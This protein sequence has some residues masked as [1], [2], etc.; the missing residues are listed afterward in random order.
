MKYTFEEIKQAQTSN[1]W[2]I[3]NNFLYE[4][5]EQYPLHNDKAVFLSKIWLIGRSYSAA[6]E[7]RKQ[8]NAIT[9]DE[10]YEDL[11]GEGILKVGSKI[12]ESIKLL[13]PHKKISFENDTKILELHHLL[14]QTFESLTGMSKRSLASKYLHF[15]LPQL[16]YIYDSR[17]RNAI[18]E[19]F[20]SDSLLNQRL[21]SLSKTLKYDDDYA[22]FSNK[23]FLLNQEIENKYDIWL[24][25]RELDNL[26]LNFNNKLF[27]FFKP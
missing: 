5:C 12:D 24:S 18:N 6:I 20:R 25:P 27:S 9:N 15:H 19:V 2:T 3:G 8:N 7:R 16:F 14:T 13:K 22:K 21:K 4:M 26:L 10:F 1:I 11:I 23:M 17:A